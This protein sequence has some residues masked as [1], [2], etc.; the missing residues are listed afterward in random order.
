MQDAMMIV[1]PSTL[2][3]M[4]VSEVQGIILV[5]LKEQ[6]NLPSPDHQICG[7]VCTI[8]VRVETTDQR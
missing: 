2:I 3:G 6:G 4:M 7:I 1:E 5:K 8:H